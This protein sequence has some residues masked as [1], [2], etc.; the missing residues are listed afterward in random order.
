MIVP[1]APNVNA[2]QG[3]KVRNQTPTNFGAPRY[4]PAQRAAIAIKTKGIPEMPRYRP[5]K[6]VG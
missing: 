6:V 1:S 4:T 5:P 3:E 2:I